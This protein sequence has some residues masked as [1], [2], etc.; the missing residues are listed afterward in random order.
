MA[1]LKFYNTATSQWE[2]IQTDV[3]ASSLPSHA[4]NH[5][6]GGSDEIDVTLLKNYNEQISTPITNLQNTASG[7]QTTTNSLQT[8]QTD[9]ENRI[10]TIEDENLN[11]RVTT[12]ETAKT[13]DETRLTNLENNS[14]TFVTPTLLNGWVQNSNDSA[15]YWK[16]KDGIVHFQLVLKNGYT[17]LNTTI[18][19]F[20]T[21]YLPDREYLLIGY[22]EGTGVTDHTVVY[23]VSNSPGAGEL[24]LMRDIGGNSLLILSGSFKAVQ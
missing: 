6:S 22:C 17:S 7:L 14:V 12:L 15:F 3:T 1:N 11:T 24:K 5:E 9:H 16:D 8:E 10:K 2:N 19:T 4:S 21:G 18:M 23:H 13:N 20:P